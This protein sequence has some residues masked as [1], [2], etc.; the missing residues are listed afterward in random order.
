MVSSLMQF[1]LHGITMLHD[2]SFNEVSVGDYHVRTTKLSYTFLF[3]PLHRLIDYY[4][5]DYLRFIHFDIF[6][7]I[8]ESNACSC[9]LLVI[10][11]VIVILPLYGYCTLMQLLLLFATNW[12][13][14]SVI[15][16]I[17]Y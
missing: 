13:L 3:C 1:H 8:N 10:V 7:G 2:K 11:C 16:N 9:L 17:G 5:V 14:L 6:S 12:V 4:D 15:V